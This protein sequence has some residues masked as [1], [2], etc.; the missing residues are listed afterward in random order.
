MVK[1]Y[2]FTQSQ[3]I[4]FA[5]SF[6]IVLL[7]NKTFFLKLFD[8][9]L[10][11]KNYTVLFGSPFI[12]AL[13]LIF[14][15]NVLLLL[16][17]RYSFQWVIATLLIIS[18]LSSY[19]IDSFGTIIDKNMLNN[20]AQTDVAEVFD[21]V[22]PKLLMYLLIG[23]AI[24]IFLLQ[25]YRI[26]FGSYKV[27]VAQKLVM[28]M[29][30]FMLIAGTYMVI[31][32]SYSSFFR[33]HSELKM[34][35]NPSYP[36][37]SFAKFV[38]IKVKGK[39]VLTPIALDAHKSV[40]DK[41]QLVIL[42][43][44]ETARAQNFSLNGYDVP[45]NPLLQSRHDIVNFS[46]FYSCGTATA[47]SVPC[48]FSKFSRSQFDDDKIYYENLVDVLQKVNTRVIWRD[49]NSGGTKGIADRVKN[50]KNL[51]GKTFD[52]VM[53]EGMQSSID[54]EHKDT[55]IVL[56]QE[57]SHG[58]TYYKRYP[59]A[60]KKFTPTC[61]TQDLEKCS[62]EEIVNTYNNT[63]LYTDFVINEAIKLLEKN[64]AQYQT[65]LFYVSDHG[66]SLGE[67]GVYLHG[68]P[69]FIAPDAQKHVPALFYFGKENQ[70]K[71]HHLAAKKAEPFSHDNLFHTMIGI[72]GIQTS[73]YDAKLDMLKL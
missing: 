48:M 35:L 32:K 10:A 59:D 17:H 39:R 16:T 3:Q 52:E 55:F 72:F 19:F 64:E 57:G 8:F 4:I 63:I 62:Q 66:E 12:L 58:P 28:A 23:G 46:N 53:L 29:V 67:N 14:V 1:K 41:K 47:V 22:T 61:D 13:L 54:E 7:F 20:M 68:L 37:A 40:N 26:N 73:D 38:A 50:V 65:T 31:G 42:I 56:H 5:V 71:M 18:S 36:I 51:G 21:L 25:R 45:T 43:V 70:V 69:Y 34:Y 11:D 49:N 6:F 27:E 15:L 60:F 9:A 33:N 44:G 2:I 30:S 24:P